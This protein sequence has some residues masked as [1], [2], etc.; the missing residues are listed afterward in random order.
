METDPHFRPARRD[1]SP[2]PDF[3]A[4]HKDVRKAMRYAYTALFYEMCATSFGGL[5]HGPFLL[6][7]TRCVSPHLAG[8][9]VSNVY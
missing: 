8:I 7:S 5:A 2:A 4:R 9:L 6:F 1:R 3:H